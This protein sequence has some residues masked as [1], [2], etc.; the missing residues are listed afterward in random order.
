MLICYVYHIL[1]L[2]VYFEYKL[3]VHKLFIFLN[4]LVVLFLDIRKFKL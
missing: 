3:S 4:N 2:Y 1:I